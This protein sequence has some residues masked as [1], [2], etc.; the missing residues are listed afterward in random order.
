T[1]VATY[2]S[3]FSRNIGPGP[4]AATTRPP[5]VGPIDRAR[6]VLTPFKVTAAGTSPAGTASSVTDCQAGVLIA[7]PTPNRRVSPSSVQGVV[8][9]ASVRTPSATS[10]ASSQPW[11]QSS[12]RRPST[13]SARAPASK[14]SS[15]IGPVVAAWTEATAIGD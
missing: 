9:P 8:A 15:I 5:T 2:A 6:L 14:P 12:S 7:T 13:T 11:V 1:V 3:A 4:A 10:I